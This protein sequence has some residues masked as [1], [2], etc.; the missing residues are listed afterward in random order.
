MLCSLVMNN[1]ISQAVVHVVMKPDGM[2][3]STFRVFQEVTVITPPWNA[4]L[5]FH[6]GKK[7]LH[8]TVDYSL[9]GE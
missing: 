2:L 1:G 4:S 8:R 5:Y 3:V 7:K 6:V 9:Q